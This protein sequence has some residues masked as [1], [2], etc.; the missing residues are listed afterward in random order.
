MDRVF[1]RFAAGAGMTPAEFKH[2]LDPTRAV[3]R[4]EQLHRFNSA[5]LTLY[6]QAV[7]MLSCAISWRNFNV[8][9]AVLAFR[10]D[11]YSYESRW[12]VFYGM[13][14][15]VQQDARNICAEPIPINAALSAAYTEI[16]GMVVVGMPQ[17]DNKGEHLTLRP[18]AHCRQLMKHHPL[19]T[20]ETVIITAVPVVD[21]AE[22]FDDIPHEAHTFQQLLEQYDEI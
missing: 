3:S 12:R 9:C 6:Y 11:A 14:T 22:V 2:Y 8:G 18:C 10:Q 4:E 1:N 7:R 17:A 21:E 5:R 16:I 13:N 19:V 15:K 20:P